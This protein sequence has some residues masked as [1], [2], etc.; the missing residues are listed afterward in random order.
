MWQLFSSKG[1]MTI[2]VITKGAMAQLNWKME[3]EGGCCFGIVDTRPR[4]DWMRVLEQQL[5]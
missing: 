2:L 5:G 1:G 4:Q 3:T